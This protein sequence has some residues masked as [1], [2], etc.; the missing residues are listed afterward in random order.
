MRRHAHTPVAHTQCHYCTHERVCLDAAQHRLLA[1]CLFTRPTHPILSSSSSW[2]EP[3]VTSVWGCG[4]SDLLPFCR[5]AIELHAPASRHT[6]PQLTRVSMQIKNYYY[7]TH[8]VYNSQH[9]DRGSDW[10]T[11]HFASFE[12]SQAPYPSAQYLSPS[13]CPVLCACKNI[14]IVSTSTS[15]KPSTAMK[16]HAPSTQDTAEHWLSHYQFVNWTMNS[17]SYF[18]LCC[19]LFS[20]CEN[21]LVL[22]GGIMFGLVIYAQGWSHSWL[23]LIFSSVCIIRKIEWVWW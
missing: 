21:L 20:L 1:L 11:Q 9:K 14:I 18:L 8:T 16:I 19:T 22:A 5:P 3:V 10:D 23:H 6:L 7:G 15:I 4:R 2:L 12:L 17:H 13:P